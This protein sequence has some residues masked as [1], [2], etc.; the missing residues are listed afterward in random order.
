MKRA[1]LFHPRVFSDKE[2][3]EGYY[4]RNAQNIK[5]VGQRFAK[6]LK[7]SGFTGGKI[8]DA[9]CGFAIIPIEIA[10]VIPGAEITGIDLGEPLLD[11]GR[12][13]IDKEEL[14]GKI[15]L[16]NGNAENVKYEN[17]SFDVVINTFLL[18]IVEKPVVMLNELERVAKPDAKIMIT[19]LRRGF[20]ALLVKKFQTAFTSEEAEKIINESNL[21]KGIL[22]NGPFWW[23]Y[24]IGI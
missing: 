18:H 23:D 20:L 2:W 9:G 1:K 8:L 6:L 7:A 4:K 14:T 12:S 5:R 16:E 17:D 22:S 11:L 13:L 15:I 24:M 3:A 19:D 21:R 10:K